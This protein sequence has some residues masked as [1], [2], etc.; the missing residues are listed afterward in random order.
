MALVVCITLTGI[1][2]AAIAAVCR[3][4]VAGAAS[5]SVVASSS[6]TADCTAGTRQPFTGRS[7]TTPHHPRSGD[8]REHWRTR[9]VLVVVLHPEWDVRG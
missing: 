1:A 8:I 5:E 4:G 7:A 9:R 6:G 3:P 2:L